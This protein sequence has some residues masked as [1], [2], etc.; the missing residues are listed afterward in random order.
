MAKKN[1]TQSKPTSTRGRGR[2]APQS[3]DASAPID[4]A[5]DMA[6][7]VGGQDGADVDDWFEA[8]RELRSRRAN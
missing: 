6:T 3:A 4:R 1:T 5:A 8:E 2:A 7:H